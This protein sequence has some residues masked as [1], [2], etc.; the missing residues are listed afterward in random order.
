MGFRIVTRSQNKEE[1]KSL[2]GLPWLKLCASNA[3]DPG[4]IPG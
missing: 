3:G 1:V 4:S 2:G